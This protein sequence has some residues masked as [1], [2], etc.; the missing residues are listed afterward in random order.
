MKNIFN[1]KLDFVLGRYVFPGGEEDTFVHLSVL[2][3]QHV[4]GG[5]TAE[6]EDVDRVLYGHLKKSTKCM[7]L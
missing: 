3:E 6:V 7:Y 1:F 2:Y 5:D 4:Q